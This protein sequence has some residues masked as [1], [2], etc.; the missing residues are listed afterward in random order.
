MSCRKRYQQSQQRFEKSRLGR[1]VY[2]VTGFVMEDRYQGKMYCAT[3]MG[4]IFTYNLPRNFQIAEREWKVLVA[5]ADRS[6]M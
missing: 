2:E 6:E 5:E 1:K 4:C 3:T